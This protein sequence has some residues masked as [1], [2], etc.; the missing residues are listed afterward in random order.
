MRFEMIRLVLIQKQNLFADNLTREDWLRISLSESFVF[1]HRRKSFHY[2]PVETDDPLIDGIP[3][4]MGRVGKQKIVKENEPPEAGLEVVTRESW[5]AAHIYIDPRHHEDGQKIAMEP[6]E[7]GDGLGIVRSM[8]SHI[9]RRYDAA[10]EAKANPIGHIRDLLSFI[11]NH[12]QDI[13]FI[14][15][16]LNVPNMFGDRTNIDSEMRHA[17]ERYK[18]KRARITLAS[19]AGMR[20]DDERIREIGAYALEGGGEIKA[21]SVNGSSFDSSKTIETVIVPTPEDAD[22]RTILSIIWDRIFR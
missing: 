21:K 7:L 3:I 2:V 18:A 1:L 8:M 14:Q 20:L 19:D 16:D 9:S 5:A 4:L 15:F 6:S 22:E 10:Y 12:P 17:R 11:E 13:S